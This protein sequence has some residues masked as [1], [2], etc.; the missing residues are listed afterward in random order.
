MDHP[1]RSISGARD[2]GTARGE[3][4][5]MIRL[6]L[7]A[8]AVA[9][10]LVAAG[11][12]DDSVVI[13][14]AQGGGAGGGTAGRGG[15]GGKAGALGSGSS[16]T[17]GTGIRGAGG[18][19]GTGGVSAAGGSSGGAAGGSGRGGSAGSGGAGGGGVGGAGGSGGGGVGGASGAGGSGR[20]GSGGSVG[21][22]GGGAAAVPAPF[23]GL[24]VPRGAAPTGRAVSPQTRPATY[25]SGA[26]SI[27]TPCS[28][29]AN[30][31]RRPSTRTEG[32]T[33]SLSRQGRAG[34]RIAMATNRGRRLR[35][36]SVLA[37]AALSDGVLVAEQPR[38]RHGRRRRARPG[39]AVGDSSVAQRLLLRALPSRRQPRLGPVDGRQPLRRHQPYRCHARRRDAGRGRVSR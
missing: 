1:N 29:T 17:G 20:G 32:R 3:T 30:R 4:T 18:G 24:V 6:A 26:R 38:Q 19:G 11:C 9:A 22:A 37:V 25:M 8:L 2:T 33:E 27:R 5:K 23:P 7:L 36:Q 14:R 28:G 21:A 31:S 34:R 39:R 35:R 13:G 16:G 10:T 12:W 15:S